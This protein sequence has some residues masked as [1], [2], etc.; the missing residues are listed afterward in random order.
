MEQTREC[1]SVQVIDRLRL[2]RGEEKRKVFI[3]S[4]VPLDITVDYQWSW[5]KLQ[6]FL[7]L[8]REA[9]GV[10]PLNPAHMMK[11]CPKSVGSE[12]TAERRS[13]E[14]KTATPLIKYIIRE[15]A[16][17]SVNYSLPSQKKPFTAIVAGNVSAGE[18]DSILAGLVE[19]EVGSLVVKISAVFLFNFTPTG[20][21]KPN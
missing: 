1:E 12:R 10:L 20:M 6:L 13:K 16:V 15:V 3:L 21:M 18:R 5:E 11:R 7:P 9:E 19:V 2:L 8:W 17:Y 14:L 4:S